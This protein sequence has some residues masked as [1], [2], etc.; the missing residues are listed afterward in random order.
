MANRRWSLGS[1]QVP[2]K[3]YYYFFNLMNKSWQILNK[4]ITNFL[5][6][7]RVVILNHQGKITK[8]NGKLGSNRKKIIYMGLN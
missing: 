3:P 1:S 7:H 2:D 5:N 6:Y 8:T 4:N